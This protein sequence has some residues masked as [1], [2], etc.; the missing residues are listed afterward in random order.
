MRHAFHNMPWTKP[1]LLALAMLAFGVAPY[2]TEPF[3]GYDPARFPTLIE[4]PSIQPAGYAFAIWGVIYLW[5]AAHA[6]FGLIQRRTDPAWDAVRAPLTVSLALGA[7]WLAIA[8]EAP[9]A[10]TLG[11]WIM[12]ATALTAFLRADPTRDRWLLIAPLAIYSGWLTA[13]ALVSTGVI[14]AGYG[15]L[16][17]TNSALVMLAVA[18]GIAVVAQ[19]RQRQMPLYGLT[20][21]WALGGIIAVNWTANPTVAYAACTGVAIMAVATAWTQIQR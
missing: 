2:V 16:S 1:V 7:V 3:T 10:A 20:V 5:L 19:S 13:A 18:L 11:I 8:N 12:Q 14:V 15:L 9:L 17:D 4:R 6:L 21:I